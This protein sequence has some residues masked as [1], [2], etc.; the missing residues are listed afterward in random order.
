VRRFVCAS[1]G[2]EWVDWG[3]KESCPVC[4][5]VGEKQPPRVTVVY[6]GSGFHGKSRGAGV[7]AKDGG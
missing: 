6:K 3:A 5:G 4:G 7:P 2:H 1:C